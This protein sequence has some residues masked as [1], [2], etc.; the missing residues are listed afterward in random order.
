MK[1]SVLLD[2]L[3]EK[4]NTYKPVKEIFSVI[5][6]SIDP[7]WKENVES[8]ACPNSESRAL[9]IWCIAHAWQRLVVGRE[10]PQSIAFSMVIHRTTGCKETTNLLSCKFFGRPYTVC[11]ETKKFADHVRNDLSLSSAT[12]PKRQPTHVTTVVSKL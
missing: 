2:T 12:I 7:S 3:I 11:R 9:K 6:Y 10:T 1:F 5:S 8:Y 4:W